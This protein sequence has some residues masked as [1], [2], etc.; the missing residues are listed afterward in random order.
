MKT[1]NDLIKAIERDII[2]NLTISTRGRKISLSEA[3]IIAKDF[4][5]NY[6]FFGYEDLF[7]KLYLLSQKHKIIRKVYVKYSPPY[8]SAKSNF[9]LKKMRAA[10]ERNDRDTALKIA[11]RI[12]YG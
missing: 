3:K 12:K 11:E 6:P 9:A 1:V 10:I 4:M 5:D 7:N 2:I 8:Y